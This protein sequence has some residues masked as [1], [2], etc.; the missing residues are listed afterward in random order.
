MSVMT[1]VWYR[2]SFRLL[3]LGWL[4]CLWPSLWSLRQD[5]RLVGAQTCP[6]WW[7]DNL[8]IIISGRESTVRMSDVNR[9]ICVEPELFPVVMSTDAVEPLACEY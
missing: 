3:C 6:C 7:T 5:H 2:I 4:R 9:D 1:F 8:D